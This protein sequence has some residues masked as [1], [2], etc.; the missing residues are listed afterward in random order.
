MYDAL[1][2]YLLG[3]KPFMFAADRAVDIKAAVKF[4]AEMKLQA[5]IVGGAE[6]WQ[7]ADILKANNVPVIVTS[8]LDLPRTD[9]DNFDVN[10]EM[11]A[12]L[13]QAGVRFCISTGDSGAESRN[14]PYNA[15]MAAAFGVP[16]DEAIKSVTLYPAQILGL[17]DKLGSLET[18]KIANVVVTDG[19]LLEART[20][21]R[22]LFINGRMVPLT[23][24]HTELYEQFKGRK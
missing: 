18:G 19:D 2:P 15:G 24:R 11:P 13:Q 4:A 14:L 10:Y 8:V 6:A 21:A 1:Q 22:Y 17:G 16:K 5:V 23:S 9:D 7:A 12:K 20:R 3:K